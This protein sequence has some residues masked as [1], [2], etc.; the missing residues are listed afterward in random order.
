MGAGGGLSPLPPP[1]SL[2]TARYS[3]QFISSRLY[4]CM[5]RRVLAAGGGSY[6]EIVLD[7]DEHPLSIY[8]EHPRQ[9]V[10]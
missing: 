5:R 8:D 7:D 6:V 1:L 10:R 4:V 9:C 2:T 3:Q